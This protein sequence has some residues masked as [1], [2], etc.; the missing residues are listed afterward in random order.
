M[1]PCAVPSCPAL[2]TRGDL[3]PVHDAAP[4]EAVDRVSPEEAAAAIAQRDRIAR[5][6]HRPLIRREQ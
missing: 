6:Y 3:C 2:A 1:K 4:L 5:M